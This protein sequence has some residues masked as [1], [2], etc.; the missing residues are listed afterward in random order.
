MTKENINELTKNLLKEIDTRL[1]I[2]ELRKNRRLIEIF[3]KEIPSIAYTERIILEQEISK[4]EFIN[5]I[6]E[7]NL[8]KEMVNKLSEENI[9]D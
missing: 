8:E 5:I 6:I 9:N 1:I 4:L 2:Q 3:Q 7:R